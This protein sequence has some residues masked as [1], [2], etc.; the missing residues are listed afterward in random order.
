LTNFLVSE[1]KRIELV[2]YREQTHHPLD[3][4]YRLAGKS[5]DPLTGR[6]LVEDDRLQV[7][8]FTFENVGQNSGDN[9]ILAFEI[10]VESAFTQAGF[11][12]DV[13]HS[14]LVKPSTSENGGSGIQ[15]LVDALLAMLGVGR[16]TLSPNH[17]CSKDIHKPLRGLSVTRASTSTGWSGTNCSR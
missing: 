11:G 8:D 12:D 4:L 7:S 15:D 2:S 14:R 3:I 16:H 9:R 13:I 5:H 6:T 1:S 10:P 17:L